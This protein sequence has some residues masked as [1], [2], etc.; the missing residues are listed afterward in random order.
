MNTINNA[1]FLT[2]YSIFQISKNL[3]IHYA[4]KRYFNLQTKCTSSIITLANGLRGNFDCELHC[5][6]LQGIAGTLQGNQSAGISNLW[7]LQVYLQFLRFLTLDKH[8]D[9][10]MEKYVYLTCY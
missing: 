5:K 8:V 4:K 6:C 7:G 1:C 3:G 2:M 10:A 9:I